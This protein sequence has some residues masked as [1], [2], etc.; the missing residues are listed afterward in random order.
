MD[1]L[2]AGRQGGV[3]DR[4]DA[5]V[6]LGRRRR[7]EADR[8]IRHRDMHRVGVGV[9]VDGDRFHAQVVAGADEPDGDLPAVRDEDATERRGGH[10]AAPSLR[11]DGRRDAQSGMLPCFFRG[12]VSRLSASIASAAISR[13]RVSDGLMTSST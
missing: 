9:A 1:R 6:A 5:Q 13:G 4:I 7:S 11:K 2:G 10:A 3:D 8:G 12:F